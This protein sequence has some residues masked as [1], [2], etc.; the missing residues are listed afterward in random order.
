M[1]QD[2]NISISSNDENIRVEIKDELKIYLKNLDIVINN[3]YA[4][5]KNILSTQIQYMREI[6]NKLWVH[7]KINQNEIGW[8][9]TFNEKNLPSSDYWFVLEYDECGIKRTFK[10]HFTLIR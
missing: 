6:L 9:G 10:S 8:D 7:G 4:K 2:K 3:H 1:I 5:I